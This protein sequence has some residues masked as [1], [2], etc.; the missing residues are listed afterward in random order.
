VVIKSEKFIGYFISNQQ[1]EYYNSDTFKKV[2]QFVQSNGRLCGL[3][4]TGHKLSL[5]IKN[6]RDIKQVFEYLK[7]MDEKVGE[8]LSEHA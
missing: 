8:D 2:L 1:S 4:E 7:Q 3:K 5:T 6:V